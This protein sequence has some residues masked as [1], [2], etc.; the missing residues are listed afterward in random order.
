MQL[1]MMYSATPRS[2]LTLMLSVGLLAGI[3]FAGLSAARHGVPFGRALDT[4]WLFPQTAESELPISEV[5][6]GQLDETRRSGES[7]RMGLHLP[8]RR[9]AAAPA[10]HGFMTGG[11]MPGRSDDNEPS[12]GGRGY[13]P[14]FGDK[15]YMAD[16]ALPDAPRESRQVAADSSRD[17]AKKFTDLG[18]SLASVTR[19]NKPVPAIEVPRMPN[20][21]G[22]V[23]DAE[24]KKELFI[25]AVLPMILATNERILQDRDRMQGLR[26]RY[27]DGLRIARKD[28]EWLKD[29]AARYNTRPYDFSALEIRVDAVPPSLA[30]A[31]AA[32]ESGW[33]SSISAQS[34][35]SL[36]GQFH[37]VSADKRT[38]V[39]ADAAPGS[40]QLR[41][42]GS[43]AESVQAYIHN[44]NTHSAY[45]PFRELR[46]KLRTNGENLKGYTLAM[47]LLAYSELGQTYI[48]AVRSLMKAEQ[49]ERF[50]EA[51]LQPQL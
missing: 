37:F 2:R 14:V 43:V 4:A 47:G 34:G 21:I 23:T 13:G 7:R 50:D 36:F 15:S 27:R 18:Y 29:L 44:L 9:P 48:D 8:A 28:D 45:R 12:L 26:Q 41:A 6:Y 16:A 30:L 42:Y 25:K 20:D 32:T 1:D 31:Q 24:Q 5:K 39:G 10:D 11:L 33:G 46:T 40:Y 51:K 22:K 3:G 49:L 19:D 35:N 17:L 38:A